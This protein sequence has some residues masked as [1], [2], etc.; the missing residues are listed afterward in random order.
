MRARTLL[1]FG[2]LSAVA[3]R[4]STRPADSAAASDSAVLAR[5]WGLAYLQ[6]NQLPQA[7]TEFR[8]VIALAPEQ[9]LGYADLGLVYLRA[10]RY[11]DT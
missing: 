7:E 6:S 10:G 2:F 1:L 8:K 3:C 11:G 9:S 4:P 5:T